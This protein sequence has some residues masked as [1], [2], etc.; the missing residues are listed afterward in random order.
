MN[1]LTFLELDCEM[2][3]LKRL[4][5]P[6]FKC[7]FVLCDFNKSSYFCTFKKDCI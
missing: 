5:P 3:I 7:S 2:N 6:V 1:G 4:W